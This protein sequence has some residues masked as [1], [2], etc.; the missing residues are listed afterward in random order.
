MA[1]E[2]IRRKGNVVG[3]SLIDWSHLSRAYGYS[4]VTYVEHDASTWVVA[5]PFMKEEAISNL[6]LQYSYSFN[7]HFRRV[8]LL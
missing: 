6:D 4:I 1:K 8:V 3:Y 5:V 2:H 7:I